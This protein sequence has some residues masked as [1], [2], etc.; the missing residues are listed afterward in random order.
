MVN[1]QK[2]DYSN[3]K[4][5]FSRTNISRQRMRECEVWRNEVKKRRKSLVG[6]ARREILPP[7]R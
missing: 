5:Q 4:N 7:M 3:K 6:R 2:L 1:I